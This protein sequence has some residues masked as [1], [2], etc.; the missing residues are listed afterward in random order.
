M[1]VFC[2]FCGIANVSGVPSCR[3]C[4][5]ALSQNSADVTTLP[6]DGQQPMPEGWDGAEAHGGVRDGAQQGNY[7]YPGGQ[8]AASQPAPLAT[9][10]VAGPYGPY[11]GAYPAQYVPVPPKPSNEAYLQG[12]PRAYQY[13]P[14][15]DQPTLNASGFFGQAVTQYPGATGA[16]PVSQMPLADAGTR[17]GAFVLDGIAMTVPLFVLLGLAAATTSPLLAFMGSL[18]FLFG[19]ALYFVACW[20]GGGQTLGYQA[21]GLRVVR[22]DGSRVGLGSAIARCV[23]LYLCFMLNIVGALGIVW[24]L[25]DDRRQGWHDKIGDTIVVKS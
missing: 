24:M 8:L 3:A 4:G 14:P 17:L 10:G 15:I 6:G 11:N 1:R 20:A 18:L 22:T 2:P 25:W 21:L 12:D 7:G 5:T 16:L 13:G 19:P 23:G 9:T